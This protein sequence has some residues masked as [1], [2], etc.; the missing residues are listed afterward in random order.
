[1]RGGG[2]STG[3]MIKNAALVLNLVE[4]TEIYQVEMGERLA[5]RQHE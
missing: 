5:K 4:Q 1:M 3:K 2:L